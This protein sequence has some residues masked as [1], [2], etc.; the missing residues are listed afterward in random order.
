MTKAAYGHLRPPP[1]LLCGLQKR[2]KRSPSHQQFPIGQSDTLLSVEQNWRTSIQPIMPAKYFDLVRSTKTTGC[3]E[4]FQLHPLMSCRCV[5]AIYI[6]LL[7]CLMFNQ[8]WVFTQL[9]FTNWPRQG[10][11]RVD[12]FY[13]FIAKCME[14]LKEYPIGMNYGPPIVHSRCHQVVK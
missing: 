10:V 11:P 5:Y 4:H 3:S 9:Q 7:L 14:C 8:P 6:N 13:N 2:Q 1:L 12:I